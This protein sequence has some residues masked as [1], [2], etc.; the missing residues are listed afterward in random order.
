MAR[1]RR[2]KDLRVTL[3]RKKYLKLKS[4][5]EKKEKEQQMSTDTS[6]GSAGVQKVITK[7]K[8]S[9]YQNFAI[10]FVRKLQRFCYGIRELVRFERHGRRPMIVD[11]DNMDGVD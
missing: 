4:D 9:P 3:L 8:L 11:D 10:K 2:K 1:F 5:A 7:A 6:S